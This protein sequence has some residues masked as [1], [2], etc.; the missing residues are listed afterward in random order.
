MFNITPS[1]RKR[2]SDNSRF[3]EVYSEDVFLN[4]LATALLTASVQPVEVAE[5]AGCSVRYAKERLREMADSGL[6]EG[7]IIGNVWTYRLRKE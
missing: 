4:A 7:R 3:E 6:I 2:T 1:V 5:H